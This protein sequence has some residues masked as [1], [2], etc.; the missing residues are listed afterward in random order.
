MAAPDDAPKFRSPKR[1]LA[2]AFR[3]SRDRWKRK[4]GE[5]R[6]QIKTL[7]VRLRDVEAS[8][9]LWKQKALHFQAQLQESRGQPPSE[10]QDQPTTTSSD[11]VSSPASLALVMR[12]LLHLAQYDKD[13]LAVGRHAS[14][15]H[16]I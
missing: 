12:L 2:R 16:L 13:S 8:R 15:A 10:P 9:D 14:L 1:A 6:Q 4:A 11:P 3:L 7:K 5:R